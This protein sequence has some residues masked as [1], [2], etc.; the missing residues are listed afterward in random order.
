MAQWKRHVRSAWGRPYIIVLKEKVLIG[1][2]RTDGW[3][4]MLVVEFAA[5][6]I[7]LFFQF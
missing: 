1:F 2:E 4:N 6:I 7:Y 3:G 5:L